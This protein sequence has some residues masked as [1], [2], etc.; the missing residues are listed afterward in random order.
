MEFSIT[1][2]CSASVVAKRVLQRMQPLALSNGASMYPR[3]HALF[4]YRRRQMKDVLRVGVITSTHGLKGEMKVFP[5]SDDPHRF[6]L[7]EDVLVGEE[8]ALSEKKIKRV[9]YFKQMVIVTLE[10]VETIEEAQRLVKKEI[11][12]TRENA[13]PLGENE[14]YA[15]DL[16]GLKVYDEDGNVL[17]EL[18][19]ILET[20]ANDVYIVEKDGRELLL[21]AIRECILEVN[22]EEGWMRVHLMEGLL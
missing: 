19:D 20:G 8:G 9:R 7:L 14:N 12:V 2:K 6:D 17:G 10:G 16:Y 3:V 13:L 22:V 15:A 18:T 5:T 1:Q 11:Y 21:P 4:Y